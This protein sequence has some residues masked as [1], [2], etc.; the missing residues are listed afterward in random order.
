MRRL[1]FCSWQTFKKRALPISADKNNQR[2][3]LFGASEEISVSIH[4]ASFASLSVEAN[5]SGSGIFS[6]DL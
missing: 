3:A 6:V 5:G 4:G 1:F 2:A